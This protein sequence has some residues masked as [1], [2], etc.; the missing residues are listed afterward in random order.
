MIMLGCGSSSEADPPPD[1]LTF[2]P[3]G[4]FDEGQ[5]EDQSVAVG[6]NPSIDTLDE[7]DQR[8]P[9]TDIQEAVTPDPGTIEMPMEADSGPPPLG[10]SGDPCTYDEECET[11]LLCNQFSCAAPGLQGDTC[12]FDDDC[13]FELVCDLGICTETGGDGQPCGIGN[14]CNSGLTC[15]G[16]LC[17]PATCVRYCHCIYANGGTTDVQATMELGPYTLGPVWSNECSAPQYIPI[18]EEGLDYEATTARGSLLDRGT[19][20]PRS[21]NHLLLVSDVTGTTAIRRDCS[22]PVTNLCGF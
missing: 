3:M 4:E 21:D 6:N 13:A 17:V 20:T 14:S 22:E 15:D 18:S 19:Y 2:E 11:A 5:P 7:A 9:G 10:S 12:A 1:L 8:P 16:D